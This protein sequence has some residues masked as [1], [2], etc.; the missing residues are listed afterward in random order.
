MAPLEG[1]QIFDGTLG[2]GG[3]SELL[4]EGG[5][6]VIGCDRD[7]AALAHAGER[8]ERFGD[9]F[10]P[11]RGNFGEIRSLL[12][13]LGVDQVDGVLL[14]V[15]VSS[16]QLDDPERGFSFRADGPLD[17]RMDDRQDLSART[18]V[19]EWDEAELRRIFFEY[20]E[21]RRG[22]RVA[23]R[24]VEARRACPIETTGQL[25]SVVESAIPKTGPKHPATKVFQ[26][27][28]IAVNDELGALERGLLGAVASLAPGGVLAVISFHSLEDRCVKRFLRDRSAPEIDRPEWPAPRPNPD[29]CLSLPVRHALAPD[30]AEQARNPRS[31]SAKLRVAIRV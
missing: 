10:L 2:G 19:N 31:R 3:H 27:I 6:H 1:K 11:V 24:I 18:V 23:R 8:L 5:A 7:A 17:M 14:D 15:G 29:F 26:A 28:R 25:A 21:E 12:D 16:R 20:G 4:L 9:R 22:A 30:P 13:D